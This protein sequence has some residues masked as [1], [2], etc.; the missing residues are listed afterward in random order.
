MNSSTRKAQYLGMPLGTASNRLK[1]MIMFSLVQ[2]LGKDSCFKCGLKIERAQDLSI[3]HIQPW[4]GIDTALFWDLQNISFSHKRCNRPHRMS[5][6]PRSRPRP[7][8]KEWCSG[9]QDFL[10]HSMF[11][12]NRSNR[13]G[14]QDYCKPCHVQRNMASRRGLASR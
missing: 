11:N 13:T 5:E 12:K 10:P 8:G 7:D 3:E 2:D 6:G 9:C 1:N 14:Y 4:E